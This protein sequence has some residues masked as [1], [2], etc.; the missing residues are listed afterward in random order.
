[1]IACR[2]PVSTPDRGA[3]LS[4]TSIF[5]D[6]G[7]WD[8]MWGEGGRVR[9]NYEW[10][11]RGASMDSDGGLWRDLLDPERGGVS[12]DRLPLMVS[13]QDW[14]MLERGL[15]QRATLLDRLLEDV[16]GPQETIQAGWLPAG[17]VYACP[18]F[19]RSAHGGTSGSTRLLRFHAADLIRTSDGGWHVVADRTGLPAGLGLALMGLC[20]SAD[21]LGGVMEDL[22]SR[23]AKRF[24]TALQG[25]WE[26]A[27]GPVLLATEGAHEDADLRWL[28]Q[29]LSW[30]VVDDDDLM[31]RGDQLHRVTP[32]GFER[33]EL[34]VQAR[35]CDGDGSVEPARGRDPGRIDLS[36]RAPRGTLQQINPPGSSLVE[37]PAWMPFL[38]RLCQHLLGEDLM[39]PSIPTWWC[40]DRQSL[41]QV[42]DTL[43][44][45][46]VE[47]IVAGR[48]GY[49]RP[50]MPIGSGDEVRIRRH[51]NLRPEC[52]VA[53]EP[54]Q[55]SWAPWTSA[56]GLARRPTVLRMFTVETPSGW[57]VLPGGLAYAFDAN[58]TP[59]ASPSST[60]PIKTVWVDPGPDPNAPS[61]PER[62]P[63][64]YRPERGPILS[65]GMAN[66]LFR[67]GQN[68]SRCDHGCRCIRAILER[69]GHGVTKA[70]D[71]LVRILS[72]HLLSHLGIYGGDPLQDPLGDR[73]PGGGLREPRP[74][75]GVPQG[76]FHRLCDPFLDQIGPCQPHLP[77][78][79]RGLIERLR[80][81]LHR[82]LDTPDRD[83][84]EDLPVLLEALR[85]SLLTGFD[86]DAT[87]RFLA[88]GWHWDQAL[89]TGTLLM[90]LL[91]SPS[92]RIRGVGRA[93]D[94]VLAS[95]K[96]RGHPPRFAGRNCGGVE[97]RVWQPQDP[98]SLLWRLFQIRDALDQV[99]GHSPGLFLNRS[100]QGITEA[101][102]EAE[103]AGAAPAGS[104]AGTE[105]AIRRIVILVRRAHEDFVEEFN[106][107]PR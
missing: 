26:G 5:P 32:A 66:R 31:F 76:W 44:R 103:R 48:P 2:N 39:L 60:P 54:I 91:I 9:A 81:Q 101:V 67:L 78:G 58:P 57:Q 29:A 52:W 68:W 102:I 40:G 19:L 90:D 53:R 69:S 42:E 10:I 4:R 38:P 28:A 35:G 43:G 85:G 92:H 98:G 6:P 49:L 104:P 46:E 17:V 86:E 33:I 99:Q 36:G 93:L 3:V 59:N 95:G 16:Y 12:L 97:D 87:G 100:R 105:E 80:C 18:R 71:P 74:R 63:R 1:M 50:R 62:R 89:Q 45:L 37:S 73:G 23:A 75:T 13:A 79:V 65:I 84:V 83:G 107:L 61:I 20:E 47:S 15:R 96:S 72:T 41:R 55:P 34:L 21:A 51:L 88:L 11:G 8:E 24:A 22:G 30:A 70:Q 14:A 106:D 56:E 77:V 82:V 64:T 25:A 94:A 7:G 27:V